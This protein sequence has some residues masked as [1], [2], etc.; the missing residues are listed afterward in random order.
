MKNEKLMI[1]PFILV[2]LRFTLLARPRLINGYKIV[3]SAFALLRYGDAICSL[4]NSKPL[5]FETS[6]MF[7][8]NVSPSTLAVPISSSKSFVWKCFS[9]IDR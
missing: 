5:V 2:I 3:Q 8:P 6:A 4:A 9:I 1:H 7:I